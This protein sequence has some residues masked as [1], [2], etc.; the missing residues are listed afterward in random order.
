MRARPATRTAR[1]A[2]W[3]AEVHAAEQLLARAL[4]ALDERAAAERRDRE[5]RID[6]W[7][8]QVHAA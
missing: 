2:M 7:F 8:R 5:E 6:A 3:D 1:G 4:A